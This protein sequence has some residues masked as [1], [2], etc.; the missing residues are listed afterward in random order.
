M[1][2]RLRSEVDWR[3]SVKCC[4]PTLGRTKGV[5][6]MSDFNISFRKLFVVP[7]DK[8]NSSLATIKVIAVS[9]VTPHKNCQ[10]SAFLRLTNFADRRF[11]PL[12][13]LWSFVASEYR[14]IWENFLKESESSDCWWKLYNFNSPE[15]L[16]FLHWLY[17]WVISR[18]RMAEVPPMFGDLG[19]SAKDL[20][21][22][23][24]SK[25]FVNILLSFRCFFTTCGGEYRI[26]PI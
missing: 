13:H 6:P 25:A 5:F 23:E 15:D 8:C 2:F 24:F 14:R 1:R 17:H 9:M 20:F 19:K 22:K 3:Y 18:S 11:G 21:E 4:Y 7:R 26:L 12:R 16:T 10:R